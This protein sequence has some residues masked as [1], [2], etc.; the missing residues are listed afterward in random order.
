[1]VFE[2]CGGRIGMIWRITGSGDH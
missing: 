2:G 1:V